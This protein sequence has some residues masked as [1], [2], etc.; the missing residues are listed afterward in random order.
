[1]NTELRAQLHSPAAQAARFR[2]CTREEILLAAIFGN[3]D[4]TMP[5]DGQPPCGHLDTWI[6][7]CP[8]CL[9]DARLQGIQLEG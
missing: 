3:L 9:E 2:G 8:N 5:G 7:A 1:M 4:T 6:Y